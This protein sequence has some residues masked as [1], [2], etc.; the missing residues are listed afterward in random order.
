[1][2]N[3]QR[4]DE[5]GSYREKI[6]Q[7]IL[8]QGKVLAY[9]SEEEFFRILENIQPDIFHIHRSGRPNEFPVVPRLK[10]YVSK[11]I[12]TNIFGGIDPTSVID[13]TLYINKFMLKA[14][15]SLNRKLGYLYN[16]VKLPTHQRN[17][18]KE[19][20]ISPH[21]FVMGRIGRPDDNIFDPIS[22]HAIKV[23]E[24]KTNYDFLYLV[25]SPPPIMI[26]TA[27]DMGLRKIKFLTVPIVSDEDVT[28]FL[29]TIDILAHARKDGET[30]GLNIAEAMIHGK[31]V[32]S[33]RSRIVNGH[34]PFV[35]KCGFFTGT[36]NYKQYAKYISILYNDK[37]KRMELGEKGRKFAMDNFLLTNIG[38]K[39]ESYYKELLTGKDK[40]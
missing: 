22:L 28:S 34:K 29:N 38:Q 4:T 15:R 24:E 20:G 27:R 33:H 3:R 19:L 39:L 36:D 30:F 14:G 26:K 23:V 32:I 7:D 12:E 11:C 10:E 31:P 35:R 8:G 16:P 18:R 37:E 21:T 13:L 2:H 17:L 5:A 40:F 1:M 6:I 25:Q 9:S